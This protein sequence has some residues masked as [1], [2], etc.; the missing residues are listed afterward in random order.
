MPDSIHK[1]CLDA[2]R[3]DIITVIPSSLSFCESAEIQVRKWPWDEKQYYQGITI[4]ENGQEMLPET[5]QR[6]NVAYRCVVTFI[7]P[8]EQNPDVLIDRLP[9]VVE[10]IRRRYTHK[11]IITS[12]TLSSGVFPCIC[13]VDPT[14]QH[15]PPKKASWT[16]PLQIDYRHLLIR[17]WV[18]ENAA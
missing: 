13:K 12:L 10:L 17:S 16:N 14:F 6:E 11:R 4:W 2:I 3:A 1:Q 9:A 8:D 5:T 18:K 7:V 15:N